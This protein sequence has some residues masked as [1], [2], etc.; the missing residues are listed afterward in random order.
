MD[1]FIDENGNRSSVQIV[2]YAIMANEPVRFNSNKE[3][4]KIQI[5]GVLV[6]FTVVGQT[7]TYHIAIKPEE[8]GS[9]SNSELVKRDTTEYRMVFRFNDIVL[10]SETESLTGKPLNLYPAILDEELEVRL[11]IRVDGEICYQFETLQLNGTM[12]CLRVLIADG[13]IYNE[14]P[15]LTRIRRAISEG[16]IVG[17]I[18]NVYQ[19]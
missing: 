7:N 15:N 19:K 2:P 3:I 6:E 18:L 8:Q 13:N 14:E 17:Y 1:Y 10:N 9:V 5:T 12:S 11:V 4:I 16:K